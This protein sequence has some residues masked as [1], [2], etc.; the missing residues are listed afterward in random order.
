MRNLLIA[1]GIALLLLQILTIIWRWIKYNNLKYEM[2]KLKEKQWKEFVES[3][4]RAS[5]P[6]ILS[7]E[8]EEKLRNSAAR[9]REENERKWKKW[10]EKNRKQK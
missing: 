1:V 8:D 6:K 10:R 9:I 5:D 7:K 2:E 4:E 3:E